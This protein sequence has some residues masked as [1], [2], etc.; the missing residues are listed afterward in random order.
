MIKAVIFDLDGVL[1]DAVKLH[2]KAFIEAIRPYKEIDEDY[3]MQHLNGLPT[4]KKLEKLGF[5][6]DI[7]EEVN[8]RKQEITFVL[9]K[10]TIKPIPQV[11]R[12]IEELKKKGLR[13]AVCSNSIR[14]SIELFLEA[15]NLEGFEFIISNQEVINPKPDPEMYIRAIDRLGL[16]RDEIIIV[17]D[18]PV[19]IEA[20]TKSGAL[21][22]P[23]KDPW[24]IEKVLFK[25][26]DYNGNYSARKPEKITNTLIFTHR[27]L[28]PSNQNFHTESSL[29]AFKDH[30]GRGFGIEFDLNFAKDGAIIFHDSNLRR[31]TEGK[32]NRDF[33]DLTISE[34][35][36][37]ALGVNKNKIA[38][39]DE[40]LSLIQNNK[41]GKNALHLKGKYQ[42]KAYLDILIDY[43]KKYPLA[44]EKIL[45]FDM[46]PETAKYLKYN[47][48][49][50]QLAPS[51]AHDFDIKRY[52]SCV[53]NTL[54]SLNDA[55]KY[56]NE[57]LYDWVWL[58]EWDTV[59]EAGTEKLLYTQENFDILR[60]AGYKISL[61]T[62]ELHGT[63]PGLYGG[64]SHKHS[65][66]KENLFARIK[67]IL[68]LQ[69][70]AICTNYPEES[71]SFLRSS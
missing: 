62:P 58:D 68:A 65:K 22:C 24:D 54:I 57:G 29:E 64:E 48:P 5:N 32:N 31:I 56:K 19:G 67:E 2:Q 39:F 12:V 25:I 49:N 61:V 8:K 52:N 17:E 50:I 18:A 9:I 20:A 45:I 63:S 55:L 34:I 6:N 7:I 28:E 36:D 27:G 43:L 46:K 23:I 37:L 10:E 4:K 41:S 14:K 44:A 13:F 70:D 16:D 38:T 42:E 59:D 71:R 66:D 15:I 51:V 30:L 35:K 53:S 60:R 1:V 3:H 69:P 40:V 33:K 47:L 21:V 11:T 26:E